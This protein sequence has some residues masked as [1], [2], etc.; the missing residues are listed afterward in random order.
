MMKK[1]NTVACADC[2]LAFHGHPELSHLY[3]GHNRVLFFR[4]PG[5]PVALLPVAS[6]A[7]AMLV[8]ERAYAT[9]AIVKTA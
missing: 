7:E 6:T 1:S 2:Q 4:F 3:C 9:A 5:R 8:V